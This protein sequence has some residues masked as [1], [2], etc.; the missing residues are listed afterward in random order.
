[1][2]FVQHVDSDCQ[3]AATHCIG[4]QTTKTGTGREQ[5]EPRMLSGHKSIASCPLSKPK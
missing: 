3:H 2:A 4:L 5:H 1:M